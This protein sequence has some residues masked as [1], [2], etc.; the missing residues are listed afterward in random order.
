[1]GPV[2]VNL[3]QWKYESPSQDVDLRDS[4]GVGQRC[5]THTCDSHIP[6]KFAI[7]VAYDMS[8]YSPQGGPF[9]RGESGWL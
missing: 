7:L 6:P 5:W 1:M 3:I 4:V 9:D 8:R 2:Q